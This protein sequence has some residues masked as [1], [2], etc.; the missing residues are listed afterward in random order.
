[1]PRRKA[2]ART[3]HPDDPKKLEAARNRATADGNPLEIEARVRGKEGGY[4]WFLIRDNPLRDED[5][6]ILRWSGTRT[7]IEGRK[8]AD[9]R[10]SQ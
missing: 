10:F 2:V 6:R 9:K 5:G 4:R 1:M 7:D 3:F 8:R